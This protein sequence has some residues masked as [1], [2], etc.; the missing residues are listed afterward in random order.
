MIPPFRDAVRQ[1]E[2]LEFGAVHHLLRGKNRAAT[3]QRKDQW[4]QTASQPQITSGITGAGI[5]MGEG[6]P[7]AKPGAGGGQRVEHVAKQQKVI[8]RNAVGMRR[9]PTLA[10]IDIT[11]GKKFAEVV[12]SAAVAEPQFQHGAV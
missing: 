11:I 12:V 6:D 3:E 2:R 4:A 8:R 9:D 1:R 5:E 7:L 10:D